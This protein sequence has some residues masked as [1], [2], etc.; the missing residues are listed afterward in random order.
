MWC[1]RL[2]THCPKP[3]C[4]ERNGCF[5]LNVGKYYFNVEMLIF[6]VNA[7]FGLCNAPLPVMQC[8]YYVL[9]C[10]S[11]KDSAPDFRS[12]TLRV[13]YAVMEILTEPKAIHICL[14]IWE[15]WFHLLKT[16]P[17]RR[18]KYTPKKNGPGG[19]FELSKPTLS[20]VN[21]SCKDK[22]TGA[23]LIG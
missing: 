12:G 3:L 23:R 19:S 13:C 8:E 1:L 15:I 6:Y 14:Q 17:R 2:K 11:E 20:N 9:A 22:S 18:D 10:L 4:F 16:T 5:S 21:V 7:H